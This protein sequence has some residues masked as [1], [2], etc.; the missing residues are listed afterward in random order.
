MLQV[1]ILEKCDDQG[2]GPHK[3]AV[4]TA[5]Q[6]AWTSSA[7]MLSTPADFLFFSECTAAST[8][9]Q[10]LG[11]FSVSVWEQFHTDG[12]PLALWLYSS[13]QYCVH[14]FSSSQSSVRYL[15]EQSWIVV[16]FPFFSAVKTFLCCSFTSESPRMFHL[17]LSILCVSSWSL[18]AVLSVL[19]FHVPM[20]MLPLPQIL[21]SAPVAC[22]TPLSWCMVQG[23]DLVDPV[24]YTHLTLPTTAEV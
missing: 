7:G 11:W 9:L 8:S 3:S 17:Y 19:M 24:S 1:A 10:S 12:S 23:K 15:S 6:S 13:E 21:D 5:S 22:L 18:P 2:L 20:V 16:A 4:I 14:Q